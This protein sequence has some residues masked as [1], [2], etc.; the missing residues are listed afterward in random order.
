MKGHPLITVLPVIEDV[1]VVVEADFLP[2]PTMKEVMLAL[3]DTR[4]YICLNGHCSKCGPNED[5]V[6]KVKTYGSQNKFICPEGH[7]IMKHFE[8]TGID[9]E[10]WRKYL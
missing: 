10:K 4:Q 9:Y 6:Y 5:K 2:I 7:D 3:I 8:D 1:Q